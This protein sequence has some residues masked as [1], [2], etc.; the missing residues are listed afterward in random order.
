M[1]TQD[2]FF[3]VVL[4]SSYQS[5]SPGDGTPNSP[6]T[7]GSKNPEQQNVGD[8]SPIVVISGCGGVGAKLFPVIGDDGGVLDIKL[9]HGGFGYKCPPQVTVID[10]NRRGSGVVASPLLVSIQVS[11]FT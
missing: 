8:G 5:W 4:S 3:L 6:S 9:I 7:G 10:P 1:V 11:Y 2:H